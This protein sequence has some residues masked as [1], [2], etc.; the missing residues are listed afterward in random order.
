[1]DDRIRN[2]LAMV[3]SLLLLLQVFAMRWNVVIGGQMFSKSMRGFRETYVPGMF[4]KEGILA[5]VVIFVMPFV[6][7]VIFDRLIPTFSQ[8]SVVEP[9]PRPAPSAGT[10]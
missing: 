8:P 2:T 9:E 4:D 10:A 3:S 5:A 6:L 7:L 1:M